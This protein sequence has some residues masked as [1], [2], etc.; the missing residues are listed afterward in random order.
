M[1]GFLLGLMTTAAD[2]SG[3]LILRYSEARMTLRTLFII[4]CIWS[5]VISFVIWSIHTLI[6]MLIMLAANENM[7]ALQRLEEGC[8]LWII[9]GLTMG[10]CVV[11]FLF[12]SSCQYWMNVVI[13]AFSIGTY[14]LAV[15]IFA[16]PSRY[17]KGNEK[18]QD[19]CSLIADDYLLVV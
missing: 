15:F 9:V 14:K 5:F 10:Y 12:S 2:L 1:L 11:D 17:E 4:S 6:F 7:E 13:M 18:F 8:L 19:K 3:F 16:Q